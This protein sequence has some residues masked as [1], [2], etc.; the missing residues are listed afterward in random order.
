LLSESD[1]NEPSDIL[2]SLALPSPDVAAASVRDA[3]RLFERTLSAWAVDALNLRRS[4]S[5]ELHWRKVNAR[6]NATAS[7]Y[8]RAA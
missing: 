8:R 5:C 4:G 2:A 6:R 7:H 3:R 1:M